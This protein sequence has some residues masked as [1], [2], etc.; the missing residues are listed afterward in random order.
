MRNLSRYRIRDNYARFYL[1]YIEPHKQQIIKGDFAASL[2]AKLP[3]WSTIMGLQFENLI[4][5]NRQHIFK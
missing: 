2:L 5:A 4:L 3:Q 1:K